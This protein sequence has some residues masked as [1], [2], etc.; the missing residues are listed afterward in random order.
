LILGQALG[1]SPE[2]VTLQLLDDMAQ[3]IAL[4]TLGQQHRL[5]LVGIVRQGFAGLR[6][7]AM[8]SQSPGTC[9]RFNEGCD[10]FLR[11]ARRHWHDGP[12]QLMN[13]PPIEAFEQGRELGRAQPHHSIMKLR[14]AELAAL[15]SLRD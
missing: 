14:P 4:G 12:L 5:E 6:H 11:S 8:E 13:A 1:T 9:D 10:R 15:Q 7:K 3:P 2:A